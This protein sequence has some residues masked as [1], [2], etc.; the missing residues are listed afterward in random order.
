MNKICLTIIMA[1]MPLFAFGQTTDQIIK[2][3]DRNQIFKTQKFK[4]RMIIEKG[5]RKLTKEFYGYG[6]KLGEKAYIKFINPEDKG[7][8]FLKLDDELWIYFPDADDIMK[9]SGHMLR[10]GMMGSDISYQDLMETEE[11]L[12]KYSYKLLK[13]TIVDNVKCY[14]VEMTAKAPDAAYARQ[15]LYI[16]K[17][18]YLPLKIEMYA[19]GGRLLK[20]LRQYN[21]KK[22]GARYV[23]GKMTIQDKRKRNSITILE[24]KEIQF[25]ISIPSKIFKK[26]NLKR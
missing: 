18:R 4:I 5:A 24:F 16:D 26:R 3:L 17:N 13:E 2:K 6:M 21:I 22:I 11:M 7:V 23:P 12:K 15:V 9:I 14:V 19:K 25:D 10:Q 8:K 1:L 20:E